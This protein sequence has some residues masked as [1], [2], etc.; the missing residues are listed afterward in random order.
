MKLDRITGNRENYGSHLQAFCTN[1]ACQNGAFGRAVSEQPQGAEKLPD[2]VHLY[3]CLTCQHRFEVEE[4]STLPAEIAP[5]V[6]LS[7]TSI[8]TSCPWCGERNEHKAESWPLVNVDGF[9]KVSPT[10]AFG[11]D[12]S[13]CHAVYVLRPQAD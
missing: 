13:E 12:C 8:M 5:V 9:F 1:P 2:N 11:V 3:E 4:T 6:S 7:A 10:T